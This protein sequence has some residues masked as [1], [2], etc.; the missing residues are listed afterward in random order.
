M[1]A[2]SSNEEQYPHNYEVGCSVCAAISAKDELPFAVLPG[3]LLHGHWVKL[4]TLHT[5]QDVTVSHG[6][7]T[8]S[9]TSS[10][11]EETEE[12][13][14]SHAW[15]VS[16]C[17]TATFGTGAVS[18]ARVEKSIEGCAGFGGETAE[19]VATTTAQE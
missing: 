14:F 4:R 10:T 3:T 17:F 15:D 19:A 11:T 18:P 12:S 5:G 13:S 6:Y 16:V 2:G 8:S 7:E 9:G 1:E